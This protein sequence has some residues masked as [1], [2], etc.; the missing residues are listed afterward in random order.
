MP[1]LWPLPVR[2]PPM[3]GSSRVLFGVLLALGPDGLALVQDG[4]AVVEH[5]ALV[6]QL[7]ELLHV[8]R[9]RAVHI[10]RAEEAH[11]GLG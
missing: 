7:D 4:G 1:A 8:E 9:A 3:F 6:H 10:L 2:L 5:V 11:L